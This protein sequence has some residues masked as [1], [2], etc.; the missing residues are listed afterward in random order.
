NPERGLF[1]TKDGG[2]TWTKSLY[3]NEDTGVVDVAIEENGRILYAAAYQRRRKAY[4]FI[5][6]GPH[7]GLYR[8]LDEGKTWE[9]LEKGLPKGDMGRIG[10]DIAKSHPNIVYTTIEHDKKPGVYKS[11]DR[12]QSWSHMNDLIRYPVYYQ[13]IRVDPKNPN[14]VWLLYQPLYVSIDGGKTF[15]KEG[16]AERVHSD[17]HALWINPHEPDHLLLGGDGGFYMSYNGGKT[18]AFIDNLPLAQFYAI[19]IDNRD[20]YWIYGGAQDNGTFGLPSRTF[21]NLGI[22]NSDL[23]TVAYG[24]GFYV[25]VDPKDPNRIFTENQEGRLIFKNMKTREERIIR[26]VPEN[27]DEKYRWN[28]NCPLVMSPHDSNVLYYGGNKIFRTS[29]AGHS[30]EVISPDLTKNL[31]WQ[32]I[33]IMDFKRGEDF[34]WRDTGGTGPHPLS[35]DYGTEDYGTITT[36]SESPVLAGV[37]YVGTD[38]GNVQLTKDGGKTWENLNERFPLKKPHW[39]SRVM[40]SCHNAGVA[41]VAFDGHHDDDFSPYIF[42][43]M[44]FGENWKNISGDIPHG[45]VVNVVVEHPRNPDLLFAGTEFGLFVSIDG[46]EKWVLAGGDLPRAPMDDIIVNARNNDLIL[47]THGR[48]FIIL[49]DI[50]MLEHL[51]EKVLESEAYLF[52]L[53]EAFQ[54]FK[55]RPIPDPGTGEFSGPNPEDGALITYYLKNDAPSKNEDQE[56]KPKV[57]IEILDSDQKVIRK[58]EGPDRR[59]LNRINWDL[60]YPLGFDPAGVGGAYYEL[61]GPWVFPGEYTIKLIARGLELT[62]RIKVS[63]EPEIEVT[64]KDLRQRFEVSMTVSAMQRAFIEGH[65]ATMKLDKEMK[66]IEDLLENK[67]D[68]SDEIK[69]KILPI[70]QGIEE[71]KAGFKAGWKNPEYY[72]MGLAGQLQASAY[73]PNQSQLRIM[74]YYMNDLTMNVKKLNSLLNKELPD[75]QGLLYQKG[76]SMVAVQPITQ[77]QRYKKQ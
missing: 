70:R 29:D 60:H 39:V 77:P 71:L 66:Q 73:P 63:L 34:S 5:G 17:H 74:N 69:N 33:P 18:W 51:N 22:M 72:I 65:R 20:P 56:E 42:K 44:D 41:Y 23:V 25:V 43:T 64:E 38:D 8:S 7:S 54:Y 4:G 24:D 55:K 31:D 58:L 2:E 32:S 16:T 3:I 76:I 37:I 15:T 26:P 45:M 30:W 67:K 36:V 28:W 14:K 1:V 10:I 75:L 48:G 21:T 47:G 27:P 11:E 6:G 19:G 53:R 59:G 62:Q 12:G 52:P 61:K 49:D 68:N 35:R 46:G 40:A 13:Q 57:K 9:R 50:S